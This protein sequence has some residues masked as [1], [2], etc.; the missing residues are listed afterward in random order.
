MFSRKASLAP[1]LRILEFV[2]TLLQIT[3]VYEALV[4]ILICFRNFPHHGLDVCAEYV[5]TIN[6]LNILDKYFMRIR[7]FLVRSQEPFAALEDC[8]EKRI[9]LLDQV[10]SS[11]SQDH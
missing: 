3:R 5:T 2:E 8:E 11:Q 4:F 1:R 9:P 7:L 10:I 6:I